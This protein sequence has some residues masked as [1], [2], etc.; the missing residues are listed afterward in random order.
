[1]EGGM[2]KGSKEGGMR[3]MMGMLASVMRRIF[4]VGGWCV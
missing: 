4:V 2:G 1:M 3:Y